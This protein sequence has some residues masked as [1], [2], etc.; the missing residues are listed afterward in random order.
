VVHRINSTVGTKIDINSLLNA[1][2]ETQRTRAE[3]AK[4]VLV[5]GLLVANAFV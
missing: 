2:A 4:K 5:I 3:R 1:R